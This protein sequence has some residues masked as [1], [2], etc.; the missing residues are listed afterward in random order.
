MA[1]KTPR[2]ADGQPDLQGVWDFRTITP[3]ERPRALGDKQVLSEEEAARFEAEEN[4]RQNRDLIDPAKGGAVY[5]AGGVVPYNE[6]WY[7]RGNTITGSRR[8]SLIV[9]PADGRLPPRTP[10]GERRAAALAEDERA[11]QA[12]RPRADSYTDRPLGE[13]CITGF[14]AGPPMMPSAY[15]NNVQIFQAPG[16]VVILNEMVHDARI[17]PLDG[18]P[19]A[20]IPQKHGDS[21]GRWE[22]DTLVV[23]TMDFAHATSLDGSSAGMRLVERFTRADADTLMY[24]FTVNQPTEWTKPWTAQ[25][26]MVRSP[27]R[28]YEY[29][30]HEGNYSLAGVLAGA[31]ADEKAAEKATK[32]R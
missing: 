5:P 22:G 4:R 11:N 29:A 7:D 20:G 2:T 21:R 26:A 18:R 6:F 3:L 16:Y 32:P 31:R 13:R 15:N 28:M 25:I 8:T 17:V 30:C 19:R 9:D 27:D 14:N 10:E 24:E 23:D 12:G 1:D